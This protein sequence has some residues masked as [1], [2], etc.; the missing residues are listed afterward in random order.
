M[1][2]TYLCFNSHLCATVQM[3]RFKRGDA[4]T[5]QTPVKNKIT[6]FLPLYIS[7]LVPTRR[8]D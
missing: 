4:E 6:D 1:I 2:E 3:R 5:E 7:P 8:R